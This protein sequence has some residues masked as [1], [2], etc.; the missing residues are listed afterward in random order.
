MR[1]SLGMYVLF[2]MSILS[3]RAQTNS[4]HVAEFPSFRVIPGNVDSDGLPISGARLCVVKPADG[5][6]LMPSHAALSSGSVVYEFGLDP[7][8]ERLSLK[9]GGSLVFFSAQF[10]GGGSGTLDRLA[11]LQLE[12]G[13]KIVNLLPFLGVTN[14]S[15]RAIWNVPEASS[16]PILVT[17]DFYWEMEKETHF[18][19]HFYIVSAYCFDAKSSRYMEAF[20]YR[21]FKKYPGLDEVDR[22]H[23]LGPEQAE[24]QRY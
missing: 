23:V 17:A 7:R 21:T 5:C 6:Y 8:S 16:F 1:R 4:P 11:I 2:A 3:L 19:R 22:V 20:S 18:S 24:M 12:N 9:D 15:E 14:Q 10:Y 13:G